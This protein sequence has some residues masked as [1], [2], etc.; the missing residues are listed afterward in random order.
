[1]TIAYMLSTAA[2]TR[3]DFPARTA[4]HGLHGK[5]SRD[6]MAVNAPVVI[7]VGTH[8]HPSSR[9]RRGSA[10]LLWRLL[11]QLIELAESIQPDSAAPERKFPTEC[12]CDVEVRV[13]G[14]P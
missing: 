4:G 14:D 1:L 3:V 9:V 5:G 12:S 8:C 10:E 13:L 7:H 6:G 2:G 11:H